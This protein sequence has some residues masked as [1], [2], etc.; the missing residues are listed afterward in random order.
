MGGNISNVINEN[1]LDSPFE[2]EGDDEYNDND[3]P[4]PTDEEFNVNED[5]DPDQLA[6][7]LEYQE[8]AQA[9][10]IFRDRRRIRKIR[11]LLW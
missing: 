10:I 6:N 4:P 11:N 7:L 2:E 5:I 8:A 9:D 3:I 1:C